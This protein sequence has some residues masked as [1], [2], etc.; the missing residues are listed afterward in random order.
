MEQLRIF[1]QI[2]VS[3]SVEKSIGSL[4]IDDDS[5]SVNS[6]EIRKNICA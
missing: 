3:D 2:P 5:D 4:F 6:Y 1:L